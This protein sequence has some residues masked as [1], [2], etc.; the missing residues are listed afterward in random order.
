MTMLEQV[1]RGIDYIEAHLDRSF[2]LTDVSRIAGMS[3]WH[4]QRMFRALTGETL[5]TYVRARRLSR[6]LI[7]LLDTDDRILEIALDAGFSS[8]ESFTRAFQR[9][10]GLAPAAF[11]RLGNRRLFPKKLRIDQA[12]LTH[13]GQHVTREPEIVHREAMAVVGMQTSFFGVDSDKNNLA[14]RIPALWDAFTPRMDELEGTRTEYYGLISCEPHSERLTYLACGDL[15]GPPPADMVVD[16]VPSGT[17]AVFEHRGPPEQLDHTVNYV[18][19]A[20]L[21][22]SKTWRH[23]YGPDLEIYGPDWAPE[24]PQSVMHYAVP[25][26][27]PDGSLR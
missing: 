13:V 8:H 14:E 26:V 21:M 25:V 22:G 24:S 12:Y 11:R 3:H 10:Y 20:W 17:W 4:F 27:Q 2:A 9:T 16:T 5:M 23:T 15:G 19:S 1:Q 18:Y 7:R 6:A